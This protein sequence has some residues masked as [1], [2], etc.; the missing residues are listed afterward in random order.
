MGGMD[1]PNCC[2]LAF[3]I[4][5]HD[6]LLDVNILYGIKEETKP[7][8]FLRILRVRMGRSEKRTGRRICLRTPTCSLLLHDRRK[9]ESVVYL[10]DENSQLI[11]QAFNEDEPLGASTL[12]GA[13]ANSDAL[14]LE[15]ITHSEEGS[16]LVDRIYARD[17]QRLH[18]Y[19]GR[20]GGWEACQKLRNL[21]NSC[22]FYMSGGLYLK[23]YRITTW[24]IYPMTRRTGRGWT[25]VTR[26]LKR[27]DGS[28]YP[29]P[30]EVVEEI[31]SG[32]RE[33]PAAFITPPTH[34]HRCE[35]EPSRG[36][37]N[38]GVL[39]PRVEIISS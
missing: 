12:L 5:S 35:I 11:V 31:E 29:T 20:R 37:G 27:E 13:L 9:E 22:R 39:P 32:N 14:R 19:W 28:R 3:T 6:T 17:P 34:G 33:I 38:D 1:A 18:R 4:L 24:K 25:E 23:F 26:N 36:Q 16:E 7:L 8:L 21:G 10:A 15:P 2:L 30:K